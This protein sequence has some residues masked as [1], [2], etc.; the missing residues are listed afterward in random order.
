MEV[1]LRFF[2]FFLHL[3]LLLRSCVKKTLFSAG[4][5]FGAIIK[6]DPPYQ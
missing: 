2:F 6:F 4:L 3:L 1:S 5:G